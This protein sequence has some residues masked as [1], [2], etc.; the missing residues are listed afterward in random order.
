MPTEAHTHFLAVGVMAAMLLCASGAPL[1]DTPTALP[2]GEE[3]MEASD[4]ISASPIWDSVINAAKQHQKAFDDEFQN[5]VSYHV[6]EN[7][8]V[9]SLPAKC[10]ISNFSKEACFHR[11]AQGLSFYTSLLKHVEKDYPSSS[12]LSEAKRN[13]VLALS[14]IRQKMKK[15]EQVSGLSSSE[16]QSLLG[17]L[18]ISDT[19]H[20]KMTAHSILRQLYIFLVDGKRALS[21]RERHKGRPAR[22]G[23]TSMLA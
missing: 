14:V 8:K 12:I 19:F 15:P 11:L 7:Y 13:T 1:R 16:E 9:S 17:P 5:Q 4:L 18:D 20:R 2:S 10:P 23:V 21:R 22:N 3:E 6:L